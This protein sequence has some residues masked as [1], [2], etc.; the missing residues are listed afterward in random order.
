M[1]FLDRILLIH[2]GQAVHVIG[3]G[4]ITIFKSSTLTPPGLGAQSSELVV[5]LGGFGDGGRVGG[6][7]ATSGQAVPRCVL[8]RIVSVPRHDE[9]VWFSTATKIALITSD[10]QCEARDT[11]GPNYFGLFGCQVRALRSSTD[12]R[13][14]PSLDAAV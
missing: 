6:E 7:V 11:N 13:N 12:R 1:I 4:G 10:R 14:C 2:R 5:A 8:P 3:P 9:L